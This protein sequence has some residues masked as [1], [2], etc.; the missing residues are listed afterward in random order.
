MSHNSYPLFVFNY[1]KQMNFEATDSPSW[2]KQTTSSLCFILGKKDSNKKHKRIKT[3]LGWYLP[4]SPSTYNSIKL[5]ILTID[6][7]A[8]VDNP[9]MGHE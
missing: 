8:T 9:Q 5:L 2:N 4:K 3:S 6:S 7:M 1:M